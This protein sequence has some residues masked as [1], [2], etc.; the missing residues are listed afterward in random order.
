MSEAAPEAPK[1]RPMK[2]PYTMSAK[3]AQF[4]YKYY[5][6]NNWVARYW[7][8]SAIACI[9]IFYSIQKLCK[10]FNWLTHRILFVELLVMF[11]R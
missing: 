10:Y 4:P 11:M 7:M 5:L 8:I 3:I 2:F 1:G 9:P 6:N